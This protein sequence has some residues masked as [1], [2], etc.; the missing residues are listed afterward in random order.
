MWNPTLHWP[1]YGINKSHV[2]TFNDKCFNNGNPNFKG[3]LTMRGTTC[4]RST[5]TI[6]ENEPSFLESGPR[7]LLL[8]LQIMN[9]MENILLMDSS[10][11]DFHWVSWH[12]A[13]TRETQTQSSFP[14]FLFSWIV[15]LWVFGHTGLVDVCRREKNKEKSVQTRWLVSDG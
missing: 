1:C 15:Q 9:S 2:G 5:L 3:L 10:E 6:N 11:S 13:L 14:F 8:C 7:T 4:S 12:G